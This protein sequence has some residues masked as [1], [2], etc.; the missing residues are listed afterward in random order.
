MWPKLSSLAFRSCH[1]VITWCSLSPWRLIEI[2][3]HKKNVCGCPGAEDSR[4][5]L[6]FPYMVTHRFW[7]LH[8]YTSGRR[9]WAQMECAVFFSCLWLWQWAPGQ[10]ER[11]SQEAPSGPGGEALELGAS[12]GQTPYWTASTTSVLLGIPLLWTWLFWK[13]LADPSQ[14]LAFL[15]LAQNLT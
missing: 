13:R 2:W 4:P 15:F 7:G 3:R 11:P 14:G 9:T 5:A 12:V 6:P 10:G 1:W 8:H